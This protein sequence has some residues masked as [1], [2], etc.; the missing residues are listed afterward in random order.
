MLTRIDNVL[1]PEQ[2]DEIFAVFDKVGFVS[3]KSTAAGSAAE[4][5]DNLQLPP[6]DPDVQR[7]M[8][9]VHD[10]LRNNRDFF[11]VAYPKRA[12]PP[13]FNRYEAGMYYGEHVDN[14]IMRMPNPVRTDIA[15]T[16]FLSDPDSYDGGELVVRMAGGETAVKLPAGSLVTYPPYFVHRVEP[17]TRGVRYAAV[18]WAE[19]MLRDPDQRAV[20]SQLDNAI[21]ALNDVP[22]VGSAERTE[23]MNVFHTLM[24][25]WVEP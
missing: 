20:M 7:I 16:L 22:G 11:N 24:R 2:L 4:A 18:T 13:M 14:A 17:V 1:S 3:G 8:K 5:K 12:F 19:S 25:M 10:A 23:L 9:L 21:R 15:L 6:D